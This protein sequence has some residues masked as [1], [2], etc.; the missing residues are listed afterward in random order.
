MCSNFL[1][2]REYTLCARRAARCYIRNKHRGNF[3]KIGARS[4]IGS[5]TMR[6]GLVLRVV[7]LAGISIRRSKQRIIVSG[8]QFQ[9]F[10]RFILQLIFTRP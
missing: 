1:H 5:K 2:A 7:L 4:P 6:D 3:C 8:A 9:L 10:A